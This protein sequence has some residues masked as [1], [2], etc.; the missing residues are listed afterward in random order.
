MGFAIKDGVGTSREARVNANNQ[1]HTFAVTETL[2]EQSTVV[3][4]SYNLNTGWISNVSGSTAL[5]YFKNNEDLPFHIDAIA[6][7]LGQDSDS[8]DVQTVRL[9]RNPTAGDIV[10]QATNV[11][12]KQNR[13]FGS[14]NQLK[15]TTLAYKTVNVATD[16]TDGD[17]IAIFSQGAGGRLFATID[18][19][20]SRGSSLGISIDTETTGSFKV[21]A[22]IIG[23]V[24][25]E[26]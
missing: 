12:M 20:L 16:F 9:V 2:N 19:E 25:S 10:T 23:Y 13:N 14:S 8:T 4:N 21:Y 5:L 22:A 18:F 15:D 1:L 3:G 11:D 7:G 17:D 6:V 26:E 24:K